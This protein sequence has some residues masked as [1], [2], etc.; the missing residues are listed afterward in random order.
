M[1]FYRFDNAAAQVGDK[2]FVS[3]PDG[4]TTRKVTEYEIVRKTPTGQV[5]LK[6]GASELRVNAHG[7]ITNDDRSTIV[8]ADRAAELRAE[9]AL[10]DAIWAARQ[11][12]DNLGKALSVR[13]TKEIHYLLATVNDAIAAAFPVG[14]AS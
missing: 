4:W 10:E 1:S 9:K 8:D 14:G 7:V 6:A 11:A 12:I 5:V 3:R 2:V 13:D